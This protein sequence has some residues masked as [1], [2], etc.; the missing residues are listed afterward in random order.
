MKNIS[1]F[2]LVFIIS[3]TT[4]AQNFF[5]NSTVNSK[6]VTKRI[7]QAENVEYF[8]VNLAAIK[9]SVQNAPYRGLISI[10]QSSFTM[11]LPNKKGGFNTYKVLRN[12]TMHPDL[13]ALFPEILTFDGIN[14]NDPLETVKLDITPQGF[15]AVIYSPEHSTIFIDPISMNS[16]G[17]VMVY[18]KKDFYT[19]KSMHCDLE[20]EIS[21]FEKKIKGSPSIPTKQYGS[22]E[23]RTYRLALAAT[24]EYTTFQGGTALLAAA[25]QVTTMNR[26]NGVYEREMA[27]TMIIVPNNNLLIFTNS[28]TDPYTNGTP[29]S[30]INENQTQCN[31]L[32]GS[33]NY[34]IGHVFGTN[35]GGLAG[36]GVVCGSS[37]ARGVTGSGAPVGDPFDIDYVAHEMGH[38]FDANHT[39]NNNCNR[40]SSTAAETGSGVTIMGYA[41]I[42]P[43]NVASNSIDHFHAVSLSEIGAFV[44]SSGHTCPVK[45]NIPNVAPLISST[46]GNTSVP[47]STPFALTCVATDADGDPLTYNWEQTD[48][49]VSTQ[50]PVSTST[51][52]P[53]FRSYTSSTNPTR[54]FPNLSD[55][56]SGATSTWEVLPSVA[57]TMNFRISIRDNHPGGG[58][59]DFDNVSV[60]TIASAGPF[61]VTY[62]NASGISLIGGT[63]HTVTWSVA[64]TTAAPISASTVNIYLSTDGGL[65]FPTQLLAGTAN[66]GLQSVSLP[67]INT[68]TARIMVI[69]GAET[70]FDISDNNFEITQATLGYTISATP[71]NQSICQG[72]NAVYTVN[73][74]AIGA[75]ATPINLTATG[76]SFGATASFVPASITPGQSSSLTISN[77]TPGTHAISIDGVSGSINNSA[78]V[79]LDVTT[80]SIGSVT[81]I[82]P[83]SG[84]TGM[85]SPV[86]LTWS[87]V[88]GVTYSVDVSTSPT[89]SSFSEQASG[90][91]TNSYTTGIL[92]NSTT[93][94]WRVNTTNGCATTSFAQA[95][96][97]TGSCYSLSAVN[98]PVTISNGAANTQTSTLVVSQTGTITSI[99]IPNITGT[100]SWV[101]DL[102]INLISPNNTS[103]TLFSGICTSNDDFDLG[104]DDAAAAGAIPCPPTT[105]FIYQP[106]GALNNLIGESVN[107]TWTLEVIDGV[108][109]DGGS[110][111][112]W[113][114]AFCLSSTCSTPT[115]PIVVGTY[116]EPNTISDGATQVYATT[117]DLIGEIQDTPGGNVLGATTMSSTLSSTVPAANTN[118]YI[119][120]RRS[121]TLSPAS[122]GEG[123]VKF[124]FTQADFDDYNANNTSF[125]DLPTSG[126]NSDPNIPYFRLYTTTTGG[127]S[128]SPPFST[129]LTWNGSEWEFSTTLQSIDATIDFATL[130]SCVGINVNNLQASNITASS[131]LMTWSSVVTTPSAGDYSFEYRFFGSSTWTF[132]GSANNAATSKTIS[133]LLSG[134]MYEI[135][136]RRNCSSQS[137]GSWSTPVVFTTIS[138]GCGSA[139]TFNSSPPSNSNSITVSWPSISGVAWYEFRYKLSSASI[140]AS[141]NTVG[142]SAVSKT[143]F[144]L[145]SGLSYDIQ[146]RSY[147]SNGTPGPWSA[148]ISATTINT[149][150]SVSPAIVTSAIGATTVTISWPLVSGAGWYAFRFKPTSSGV[151]QNGG[152]SSGSTTSKLYFGLTSGDTYDFEGR[153]YCPNGT[154]SDWSAIIFTTVAPSGCY[155]APV[156]NTSA[157][158]TSASS[159][160]ISWTSV[161]G[162][163][164]YSFQYKESTSS[165]WLTGGTAS[166]SVTNKMYVG[167]NSSTQYDFRGRS[168]CSNGAPS[169]WGTLVQHSTNGPSALLIGDNKPNNIIV[170]A[171]LITNDGIIVYPNPTKGKFSIEVNILNDNSE[172]YYAILDNSGRVVLKTNL[173]GE[174]GRQKQDMDLTNLKDGVYCLIIYSDGSRVAIKRIVKN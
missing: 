22:C 75:Y 139:M 45:T 106:S 21:K 19:T 154:S 133:G 124:Y 116:S 143:I 96:F 7:I 173:K 52:G 164:W 99:N 4:S 147:C 30:M 35:S 135:R 149:G 113:S 100:H 101:S 58:C 108:N 73:T 146:G 114:L 50:S 112:A 39:Q 25:A 29:S 105:G 5:Q 128:F 136:I 11:K 117:C 70:F 28:A 97:T 49:Q 48:V 31:A 131:V 109:Q 144:G 134:T 90:L 10:H 170:K 158:S 150:C 44:T 89:F 122:D 123:I 130:P 172:I 26:V 38:Q 36:L 66:D 6:E 16:P 126:N 162:A 160:Q 157:L 127:Y 118:G 88:A 161:T 14:T 27:I 104:F 34:D 132:G 165:T 57:R 20:T 72:T 77:A 17:K 156:L 94:Y 174:A 83:L 152:T 63:S 107:G 41:G 1:L 51:S 59:S 93:Y 76:L 40:N 24:G 171:S 32:I 78:G 69:S 159:I 47:I 138:T 168:F 155:L 125:L 60:S 169:E 33:A 2:F 46:I 43:P 64:N 74:V 12:K 87:S 129:G 13:N 140:W 84:T 65:T 86:S 3:L 23:L 142:G 71:S 110:L 56:S 54:Y 85:T 62:P 119:H 111:D 42:C 167:L 67:N 115:V 95:N 102:T 98:V 141:G 68:T 9:Q 15:H 79:S 153:T 163:G 18:Y 148:S 145:S 151:W 91:T 61:V 137:S 55:L 103:V 81:I 120:G 53:S 92:S 82:S 80:N 121:Y 37:K 8:I 166:G